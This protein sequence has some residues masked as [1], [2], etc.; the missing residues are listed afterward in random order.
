MKNLN[1][2]SSKPVSVQIQRKAAEDDGQR[3]QHPLFR[4]HARQEL[5]MNGLKRFER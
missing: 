2:L 5:T 4:G 3:D 1:L